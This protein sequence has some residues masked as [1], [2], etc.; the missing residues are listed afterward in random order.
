MLQK[1]KNSKRIYCQILHAKTNCDG[2]KDQG[3]TYPSGEAQ[4]MLLR[5][6]YNECKIDPTS[7]SFLEA[8]G[9]G[10]KVGDPEELNA[11][12]D[13]FCT[14]DDKSILI[15]SVKSNIG[16]TEPVSGVCSVIKA[17]IGMENGYIPP[18]L[19]YTTP[20]KGVKSLED[21]KLEVVVDKTP[22]RDDRGLIG[23]NSFG[24]GGGNCHVLLKWNEKR[25][26]N[27]GHPQD[28]LPRLVCVSG[29]IQETVNNILNDVKQFFDVEHVKLL[30]S[31]YLKHHDSNLVRGYSIVSKSGEICRNV[32]PFFDNPKPFYFIF[33]S[34]DKYWQNL[35]RNLYVLPTFVESIQRIHNLL[36]KKGIN[37][38]EILFDD[39]LDNQILN[40]L[41]YISVQLAIV[42]L[43]KTLNLTPDKVFGY[44]LGEIICGYYDG[45]LTLE[46]ALH[47]S[48]V[49][50]KNIKIVNKTV[51]QYLV[52][53]TSEEVTKKK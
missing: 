49:I 51:Y 39:K 38:K 12:S 16:H 36:V 19:H 27:N 4:R 9:T 13:I 48:Y 30:H 45:V 43:L 32:E 20:R 42:D 23:I 22:F 21:G 46:E 41:G 25:K 35:G 50:L 37:L 28:D 1:S 2:F 53:Q 40:Y 17:I 26:I 10:T 6:F 33:G 52:R 5:D 31:L 24:F 14:N 3:I 18:N 29:R 44:S 47:C 34:Y 11:I 8:H 7:L 15:G